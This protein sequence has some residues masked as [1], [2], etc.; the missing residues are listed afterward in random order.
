M[1]YCFKKFPM[2]IVTLTFLGV[3][4]CACFALPNGTFYFYPRPLDTLEVCTEFSGQSKF[5]YAK[6][7]VYLHKSDLFL[8]DRY[9]YSLKECL[10]AM[11]STYNDN[12]G[13]LFFNLMNM[14][15]MNQA[16]ADT[17]SYYNSDSKGRFKGV[18][19]VKFFLGPNGAQTELMRGAEMIRRK[20]VLGVVEKESTSDMYPKSFFRQ[21]VKAGQLQ[22]IPKSYLQ[23]NAWHL[24][25]VNFQP[26]Y[27][28]EMHDIFGGILM[29]A[30]AYIDEA[31]VMKMLANMT[32]PVYLDIPPKPEESAAWRMTV[33]S[34][35]M[36]V[37][38]VLVGFKIVF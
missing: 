25:N 18:P 35:W 20:I 11:E 13:L 21:L 6:C 31:K 9:R 7:N 19:I 27:P 5:S 17:V 12:T 36:M 32:M 26:E 22:F 37:S 30:D 15:E 38:S 3:C 28:E 10:K 29:W 2:K 23:L 14:V 8:D 33:T 24:T 1:L 16:L 34:V 4:L